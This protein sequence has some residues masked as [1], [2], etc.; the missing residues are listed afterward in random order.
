MVGHE[1]AN[2]RAVLTLLDAF[3]RVINRFV[4]PVARQRAFRSSARR[5]SIACNR[6]HLCREH[7]GVRR[8]HQVFDQ[9][10]FQTQT[11]NAERSVLIV[12]MQIARVVSRF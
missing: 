2:R 12:E 1:R 11:G 8:D 4:E 3:R 6:L 5:F 9:A 10:A 7:R